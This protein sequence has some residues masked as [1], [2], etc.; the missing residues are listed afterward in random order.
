L[1]GPN[2]AHQRF[3]RQ[4]IATL[5]LVGNVGASR[6]SGDYFSPNPNPLVHTWSLSVEEQI[7][8]FLPLTLMLILHNRRSLK[9]ITVVILGVISALSFVSFLFPTILQPLYSRASIEFASQFSFYSPIDRIWQFT[10]GGL[11]FLLLDRNQNRTRSI[12]KGIN[13]L[14]VIA[15]VMNL[16]GPLHMNLKISSILASL[17]A[18]IVI[19]FK[20]L[21]VLP[22]FLI[23]KI[24]WVGDRSYSIY[25]VH[26]PLLYIAKY[27]P[28]TQI[29]VGENRKVQSVI[30]VVASIFL[31]ALSF[32]RIE[33]RF[34]NRGKSYLIRSK[35]LAVTLALT[36]LFPLMLFLV[37]D[38]V[39]VSYR[40]DASMPIPSKPLPWAWDSKCE[41]MGT[42]SKIEKPCVY[43]NQESDKTILLIGDSHAAS[44]SRAIIEVAE[45]NN[46]KVSVFTQSSC[47]FI[48]NKTELSATYELPGLNTNCMKHNQEILDYIKIYKPTVTILSMHST[49]TYIIPNTESSRMLYRKS[50]LNSLS[51]LNQ[52]KTNII[53]IGTE[54][55]YIP[56]S[57]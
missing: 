46:M 55:E 24:E 4:G 15:V 16:F 23:K 45:T 27:S 44:S 6:Y 8:I 19:L 29:G 40:P 33:N 22:D 42:V 34:R 12:P 28:L 39:A 51:H 49:N 32:S 18:V 20:S 10:A 13:L 43:G 5:L 38:H 1:L 30:A 53:L 52:S 56:V 41:L 7:Y 48:I 14:T 17:F 50:I 36:L 3:A 57:T 11:A 31:G 35:N 25:L 2:S 21:D 26:M 47:P 9:K 54:P 37:M